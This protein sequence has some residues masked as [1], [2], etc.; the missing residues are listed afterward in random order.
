MRQLQAEA[1][2]RRIKESE[3][4]GIKNVESVRRQQE[5]RNALEALEAKQGT[6]SNDGNLKV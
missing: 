5:K 3:N 4:R 6:S 2:E 1:A